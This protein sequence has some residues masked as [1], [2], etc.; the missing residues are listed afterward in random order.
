MI[1]FKRVLDYLDLSDFD[2]LLLTSKQ[3]VYFLDEINSQWRDKKILAVGKQTARVCKE[4][5][6]KD[7]YNPKEFY[8]ESL[9]NDILNRFKDAKILYVRPRVVSF[10]SKAFL[11]NAGINIKEAI[12]Y[13]TT[14]IQYENKILD[15]HAVIIFTS[16][17]TIECFFK[18]FKWKGSY[19]AV[20]IGKS[21][22]TKLPKHVNA[23]V[24]EEPTIASCIETAQKL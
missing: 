12:L 10:D 5:G 19:T 17:S 6:A 14:C 8:A 3:A 7:I 24:A 22:L 11:S 16:P 20:V 15:E 9:A 23:F 4:L 2:T 13:E 18:S 1:K 21:T